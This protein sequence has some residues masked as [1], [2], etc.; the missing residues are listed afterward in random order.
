M[1]FCSFFFGKFDIV[2]WCIDFG[3][4]FYSQ[5]FCFYKEQLVW[6]LGMRICYRIYI[7]VLFLIFMVIILNFG[8]FNF[9]DVGDI[10]YI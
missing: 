10:Y 3:C 7:F 1:I 2:D 9:M 6:G 8:E 4:S 5:E